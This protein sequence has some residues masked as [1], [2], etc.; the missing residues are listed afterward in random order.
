[1]ENK[2][3]GI[4]RIDDNMEVE[5]DDYPSGLTFQVAREALKDE[6]RAFVTAAQEDLVD[7]ADFDD[8]GIDF[9]RRCRFCIVDSD[10]NE[11]DPKTAQI[12]S[13]LLN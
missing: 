11:V 6:F 7:A 8:C 2:T 5:T 1:M 4:V 10:G 12:I 3:Y 13:P 9:S